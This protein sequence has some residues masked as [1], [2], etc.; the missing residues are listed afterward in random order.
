MLTD[1]G[2]TQGPLVRLSITDEYEETV[3]CNSPATPSQAAAAAR[4]DPEP[5]P[6]YI[7]PELISGGNAA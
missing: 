3:D 2:P 6:A 1:D 7:L 5:G 4:I